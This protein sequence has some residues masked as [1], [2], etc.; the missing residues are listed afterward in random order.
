MRIHT[1][2]ALTF[3]FGATLGYLL[4]LALPLLIVIA[5]PNITTGTTVTV[6]VA[7]ALAD[8][9]VAIALFGLS[10]WYS[11]RAGRGELFSIPLVS[12]FSDAVFRTRR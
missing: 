5:D 8:F 11:A 9:I 1:R 12:Q 4:L 3:G 10:L 7:G 2:Q 6:Y